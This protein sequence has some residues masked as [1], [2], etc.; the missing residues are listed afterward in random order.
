MSIL[1]LFPWFFDDV[2]RTLLQKLRRLH[3]K[4]TSDFE[5]R[6]QA[7]FLL[8]SLQFSV[9]NSIESEKKSEG[10]LRQFQFG[11]KLFQDSSKLDTL[12][13]LDLPL[14]RFLPLAFH[15]EHGL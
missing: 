3:F 10:F 8:R 13:V 1:S 9:V 6:S 15:A 2:P 4:G 12:R 14:A 5:D 11:T 7:G